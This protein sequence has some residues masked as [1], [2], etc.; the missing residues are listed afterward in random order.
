M[1][2][3][4]ADTREA[5]WLATSGDGLPAL[6]TTAGGP[7]EVV[8]AF[9]PVARRRHQATTIYVKSLRTS[10]QRVSSQRIRSQYE[11]M[12]ELNWPVRT[13]EPPIAETEMQNLKNAVDLVL[14]RVR[15]PVGDKSHGGR[16]LSVAEVPRN[17]DVVFADPELTIPAGKYVSAV[18]AYRAD[19]YEVSG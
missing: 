12:L 9:D 11:I 14:Q 8:Q 18:I 1:S 4:T 13:T 17:A 5:A 16:F 2:T 7:W 3:A 15:G 6:L 19:D 10:D